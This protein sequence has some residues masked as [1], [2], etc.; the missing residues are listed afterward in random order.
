MRLCEVAVIWPDIWKNHVG[1]FCTA[2]LEQGH[3]IRYHL[4]TAWTLSFSGGQ[5]GA[6]A[7]LPVHSEGPLF[8]R[9]KVVPT[10][11]RGKHLLISPSG[12]WDVRA[13]KKKNMANKGPWLD[14]I[15]PPQKWVENPQNFTHL[16]SFGTPNLLPSHLCE[17]HCDLATCWRPQVWNSA[18]KLDPYFMAF[19]NPHLKLGSFSSPPPPNFFL[20]PTNKHLLPFFKQNLHSPTC[21]KG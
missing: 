9:P 13:V 21:L 4:I 11:N 14:P 1:S 15:L 6:K 2:F 7:P 8:F 20:G 5:R 3:P 18:L 12:P 16:H 17:L 19:Y 10:K